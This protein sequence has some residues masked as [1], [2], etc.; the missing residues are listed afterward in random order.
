MDETKQIISFD[1]GICNLAYC[2]MQW[3]SQTDVK[4][5]KW[6]VLNFGKDIDRRDL[7]ALTLKLLGSLKERFDDVSM[8]G[9]CIIAIENQPAV[10]NPTMKTIQ[11]IIYT[12]FHILKIQTYPSLIIKLVSAWNKL[13][14]K[15]QPTDVFEKTKHISQKYSK[16]K[17]LAEIICKHYITNVYS[18]DRSLVQLYDKNKKKDDLADS[19]LQGVFLIETFQNV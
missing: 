11:N 2:Y 7:S 4:I 1:V 8:N 13:K 3:C 15:K 16:N 10:K 9:V 14:V 17:K 12:Y 6:E 18:I 5:I 19:F